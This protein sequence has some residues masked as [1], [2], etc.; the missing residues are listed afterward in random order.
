MQ[1]T[2]ES[3][4]SG[5]PHAGDF[6]IMQVH[7]GSPAISATVGNR[8]DQADQGLEEVILSLPASPTSLAQSI[9][10]RCSNN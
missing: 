7:G 2:L 9:S 10:P 1:S 3:E 5:P 6:E 8:E 4:E